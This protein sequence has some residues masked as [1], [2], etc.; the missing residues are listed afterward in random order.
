LVRHPDPDNGD[1]AGTDTA[2]GDN[3]D[4]ASGSVGQ[5]SADERAL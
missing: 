4:D 3:A 1:R 5:L 2:S